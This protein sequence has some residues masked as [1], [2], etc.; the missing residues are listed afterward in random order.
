M[1][2]KD[3]TLLILVTSISLLLVSIGLILF[4]VFFIKTKNKNIKQQYDLKNQFEKELFATQI[5]IKDQVLQHVGRELHDNVGQ[6]LTV[7]RI[8]LKTL[9]KSDENP[10]RFDEINRSTLKALEELR[11]LSRTLVNEG[12]QKSKSL[13]KYVQEDVA[14]IRRMDILEV[15]LH[16]I[17]EQKDLDSNKEI[18]CYRI[19]QEFVTNSFKYAACSKLIFELIYLNDSFTFIMKDNGKGF[20]I[21][22]ISK[23]NGLSNI[24]NRARMLGAILTIT[25]KPNQGTHLILKIPN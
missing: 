16:I 24:E 9:I 23:G 15:E 4:L 20:D 2:D 5:E 21:D 10:S 11:Q 1:V 7:S 22:K 6:L 3:I 17:G 12:L 19:F 25:S 18:I 8:H 13:I 14:T